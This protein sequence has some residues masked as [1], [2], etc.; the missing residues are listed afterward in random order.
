[1]RLSGVFA[2]EQAYIGPTVPSAQEALRAGELR[3]AIEAARQPVRV[4]I[5]GA[6]LEELPPVVS[7]LLL[8]ILEKTAAGQ[9]ITL[10]TMQPE[11]GMQEAA[12]VLNVPQAYLLG[13]I[14][15][16]TLPSRMA[17]TQTRLPLSEV[18]AYK[19]D[20]R[21]KRREILREMAQLDQEMGLI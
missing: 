18:L 16:G 19:A 13:M 6:R 3:H 8:D 1:M 20:N 9:T 12:Y 11:I 17:G 5:E 2:M 10:S 14:E 4:L 15:K 7:R 21:A